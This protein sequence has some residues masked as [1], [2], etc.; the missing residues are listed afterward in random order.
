M[1]NLPIEAITPELLS[2]IEHTDCILS[3]PPG[4]GKSTYL[5]LQLLLLP[6]FAN[7]KILLLQPRQVA[8]RAIA[9]FLAFSVNENV[10]QTVGYQMRGES[11]VSDKTR[12]CVIT[13]G[14]LVAKLQ[15]DPELSDVGL[16]IFDEFH[17]RS[18]QS[19]IALGLS[20]EVQCG[21]R[22]D[23]RL[24]VMSA[25]LNVAEL[26]I[27]MPEAKQLSSTGRSYPIDYLYTPVPSFTNSQRSN[28]NANT[29]LIN[30]VVS[31][32]GHA[33]SN[34]DGNILVFLSG[35]GVINRVKTALDRLDLNNVLITPLY[36]ALSS[37]QQK[38]AIDIPPTGLRKIVLATN[39]A[40]TS[41]TIDGVNIVVDSGR[42]KVQ[43]F[44]VARKL[45]Q[46]IEQMISK[47]SSIQRAGRA[48]RQQSGVCYRLWTQEQQQFLQ[49]NTPAQITQVD[50]SQTLL[51]LLEWG[52]DFEQLPLINKPTKAQIEYAF[53]LLKLLGLVNNKHQITADGKLACQFNTHPRLARILVNAAQHAGEP[54]KLLSAIVV[55]VIE[56]K[57]LEPIVGSNDIVVQCR[58]VAA[59]LASKTQQKGLFEYR[60]DIA[61]IAKQLGIGHVSSLSLTKL[62]NQHEMVES[63]ANILLTAFSDKV[64]RKRINAGYILADGTGAEFMQNDEHEE[65]EWI[66]CT[67]TQLSHKING[68][69]RQYCEISGNALSTF[70]DTN[71]HTNKQQRWNESLA[72][73]VCK[74]VVSIGAIEISSQACSFTANSE[75]SSLILSQIR[76]KGLHTLLGKANTL[77]SRMQ[78]VKHLADEHLEN[79]PDVSES[80]LT[81]TIEIWLAPYLTNIITWQQ[82]SI[83]NWVDIV[84]STLTY[85]Q[86]QY[87]GD[88]F[89]THFI[90]PTG[91]QHKL[92]YSEE[93]KVTLAIRIQELYGLGQHP[94]I[95]KSKLPITL[96]LLSPAH[97]E[98]QKT[99]DLPNFWTGSYVAVQKDMRGRYPRH[100]WPDRP[101]TALPTTKTKNKM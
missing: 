3:A 93:G 96:S 35:A 67:H 57:T 70:I 68:I 62:L 85:S 97:R 29:Q 40:E 32:V 75:T 80:S 15:S 10:G 20:L 94:T 26:A 12:L 91:H 52:T 65:P 101:E 9:N 39:I 56:G 99:A 89:P 86:Q 11:S 90:A 25:T 59:Q 42:E 77:I 37:Q 54:F 76:K 2:V 98:I 61:R 55:A 5:P 31:T 8:V 60:K 78:L 92:D 81:N 41:L 23:L 17:E 45:N 43:R 48:G 66:I 71:T 73:V 64:G 51:T 4:A 87:L 47:A 83:L 13:E 74:Q 16:I 19:D 46:L 82:L 58:Y 72:K 33:Y 63:T 1:K 7:K 22:D 21:L 6:C 95:G 88:N 27:L 44:V 49:E 84:K 34:Y 30:T 28:F 18:V 36:G 38:Q 14:L 79:F 24:L 100:Y 53:G 69:V 50:I